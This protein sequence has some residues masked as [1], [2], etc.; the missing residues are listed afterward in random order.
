MGFGPG[1]G[2]AEG[3]RAPPKGAMEDPSMQPLMIALAIATPVL[4]GLIF[5]YQRSGA[6]RAPRRGRLVLLALAGP[7]NLIVWLLL[8][9]RLAGIESRSLIGIILAV[10]VFLTL[11]FGFG[12]LR[13][14]DGGSRAEKENE[15]DRAS[16]D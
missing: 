4:A 8:N 9:E 16:G 10:V 14:R 15:S 11:G 3:V 1:S 7:L 2:R 13:R 6:I 12:F 5:L